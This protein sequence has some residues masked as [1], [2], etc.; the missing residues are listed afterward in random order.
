MQ[1]RK[2][3]IKILLKLLLLP[4]AI[5]LKL[6]ILAALLVL[7][8]LHLICKAVMSLSGL[9]LG[10]LNLLMAAGVVLM[11]LMD[12][13]MAFAK[14]AV[15]IFACEAGFDLMVGLISA[16]IDI[17]RELLQGQLFKPMISVEEDLM[18]EAV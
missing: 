2:I 11:Y 16:S 9:V 7:G 17:A 13:D 14:T 1:R 4:V 15:V 8:T 6:L 18:R 5:S 12:H 3:I 10:F